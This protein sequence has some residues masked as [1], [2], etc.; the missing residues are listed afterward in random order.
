MILILDLP[1]LYM[2]EYQCN[3]I[4]TTYAVY[5]HRVVHAAAIQAPGLVFR[6]ATII[7]A[8][9]FEGASKTGG[10]VYRGELLFRKIR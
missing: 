9:I 7:K 8:R 3:C 6:G 4:I 5:L 2:C 1:Q 10:L